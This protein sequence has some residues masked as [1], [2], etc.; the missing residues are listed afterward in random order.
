MRIRISKFLEDLSNGTI[1]SERLWEIIW[2]FLRR[3]ENLRRIF[4]WD[5]TKRHQGL[6]AFILRQHEK[7]FGI[8]EV[9]LKELE[10]WGWQV[11][12]HGEIP[13]Q[14][15]QTMAEM[16]PSPFWDGEHPYQ[17]IVC[18]DTK[19]RAMYPLYFRKFPKMDNARLLCKHLIRSVI[20]AI[21]P[22]AYQAN[23]LHSSDNV[24]DAW[25]YIRLS[26]PDRIPTIKNEIER[27]FPI[28]RKCGPRAFMRLEEDRFICYRCG[29]SR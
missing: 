2:N 27:R 5:E 16:T 23:Y 10:R 22:V 15:K 20:N 18:F 14:G 3:E 4:R 28:C 25:L 21:L 1:T 13:D 11:L 26:M 29:R 9:A 17:C 7:R 8:L 12:V 24:E 6:G 19:P